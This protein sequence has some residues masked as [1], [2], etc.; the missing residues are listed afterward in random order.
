MEFKKALSKCMQI[1]SRKECCKWDIYKK[2]E[3]WEVNKN[4]A[5]NIIQTL[6]QQQFIDEN[7][8]AK[9]FANDKFRFNHWGKRKIKFNLKQKNIE[10]NIIEYAL[11]KIDKDEY[12]KVIKSEIEK[13]WN[14][15]KAKSDFERKQKVIAYMA[16]KGFEVGLITNFF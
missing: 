15:T 7:R 3:L 16:S 14:K 9:A 6:E 10:N 11:S 8:F 4:D 1:C 5:E 2:L 12:D 13:K